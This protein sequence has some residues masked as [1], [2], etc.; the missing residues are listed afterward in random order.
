M[1]LRESVDMMIVHRSAQP[2]EFPSRQTLTPARLGHGESFSHPHGLTTLSTLRNHRKAGA[3]ARQQVAG[4]FF[5]LQDFGSLFRTTC[6]SFG[7]ADA[8]DLVVVVPL[9][10]LSEGTLQFEAPPPFSGPPAGHGT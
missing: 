8:P 3:I 6:A 4:A 7:A 10:R 2:N 9:S 1:P 5:P